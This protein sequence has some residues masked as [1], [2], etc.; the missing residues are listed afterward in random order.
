MA[1]NMASGNHRVNPS[2][3]LS[4]FQV[5]T[6]PSSANALRIPFNGTSSGLDERI[7]AHTLAATELNEEAQRLEYVHLRAGRL[8]QV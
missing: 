1:L 5:R 8:G 7:S 3:I 6:Q 2:S 4:R